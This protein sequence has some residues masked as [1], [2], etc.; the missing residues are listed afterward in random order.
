MQATIALAH[1]SWQSC[2]CKRR[3]RLSSLSSHGLAVWFPMPPTMPP[4]RSPQS[5]LAILP[6]RLRRKASA[7][8]NPQGNTACTMCLKALTPE[9]LSRNARTPP[10]PNPCSCASGRVAGTHG[11][12][13]PI[14]LGHFWGAN[15]GGHPQESGRTRPH[16]AYLD[17][18]VGGR[19]G[20]G[21]QNPPPV[22]QKRRRQ[23]GSPQSELYEANCLGD[24]G[25]PSPFRTFGTFFSPYAG[26]SED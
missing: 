1:A 13:M 15:S 18:S 25:D 5:G 4:Q 20:S 10:S 26:P 3:N 8:S 14:Q 19:I 11:E 6:K 22:N 24:T 9:P 17:L 16:R 23:R 7:E 12:H 2:C 21:P